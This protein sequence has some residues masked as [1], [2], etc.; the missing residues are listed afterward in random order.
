VEGEAG[1]GAGEG[2]DLRGY[3]YFFSFIYDSTKKT[4]FVAV[5]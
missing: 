5:R 4:M 3:N 1:G 2:I